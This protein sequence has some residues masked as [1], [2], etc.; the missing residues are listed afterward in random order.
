VGCG[1][2][3][4]ALAAEA[5]MT[6]RLHRAAGVRFGT[7]APRAAPGVEVVVGLGV[8]GLRL[9]APCRVV[10]TLEEE[11]RSGWA[12][13]TLPGHPVRGEEAFTVC[14]DEDGTVR[15]EVLAFSRPATWPTRAAGPLLPVFQRWYAR[16]CGRVLRRLVRRGR[17]ADPGAS[18]GERDDRSG[19]RNGGRSEGDE[20]GTERTEQP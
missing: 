1:D 2:A 3:D 8:G 18:R 6:W 20:S 14:Q 16:R 9:S 15:L 11:G 17:D 7:D 4:F 19:D 13:G 10:W 12:Y 5:V